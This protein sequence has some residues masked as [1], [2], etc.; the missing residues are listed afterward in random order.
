MDLGLGQLTGGGGV[1]VGSKRFWPKYPVLKKLANPT[2]PC[3]VTTPGERHGTIRRH[4]T[5]QSDAAE[6]LAGIDF[7]RWRLCRPVPMQVGGVTKGFNLGGL[8]DT[9]PQDGASR[10]PG[11]SGFSPSA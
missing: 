4:G 8:P 6:D 5:V 2:P 10:F 7:A 3:W 1:G 11:A 9:L